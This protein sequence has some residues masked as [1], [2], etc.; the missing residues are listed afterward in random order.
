MNLAVKPGDMVVI[1]ELPPPD[2]MQ[3]PP[4]V[5]RVGAVERVVSVNCVYRSGFLAISFESGI[6]GLGGIKCRV[7]V[8][9]VTGK[10]VHSEHS[11]WGS[12]SLQPA[13][14][15]TGGGQLTTA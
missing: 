4:V 11:G 2:P 10:T 15:R 9:K 3:I 12:D 13:P 5:G 14:A 6:G 1:E 8:L 7:R